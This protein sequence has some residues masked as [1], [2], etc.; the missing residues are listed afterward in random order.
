MEDARSE[1][2]MSTSPG[3][4]NIDPMIVNPKS[5]KNAELITYFEVL[6]ERHRNLEKDYKNLEKDHN[7]LKNPSLLQRMKRIV[8]GILINICL[9]LS[10]LASSYGINLLTSKPPASGA[11]NIVLFAIILYGIGT[12][13]QLIGGPN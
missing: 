13:F 9:L 11:S 3:L 1:T 6:R 5:L 2:S 10:G 7:S 12:G 4:P 8:F